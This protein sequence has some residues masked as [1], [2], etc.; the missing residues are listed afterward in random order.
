VQRIEHRHHTVLERLSDATIQPL[1][2]LPIALTVILVTFA[3]IRLI[4]EGLITLLLDPLFEVYRHAVMKLSGALGPGFL[5]EILIGKLID[6]KIDFVQSMGLLTTGLYVPF[7]MVLPYIFAFYLILSLLED[8]GYLPRLSVLLD[9]VFHKIGLHG[10]GIVTV[11]LGLGCNVPGALS[12]RILETRKQRFISA[13]LLC[14]S[15]PCMAQSAMIFGIL[16]RH[17]LGY[18]LIVFAT[19]VCVYLTAGLLLNRFLPGESPE[20]FLEI[21]PYRRPGIRPLLK[22][23]LMRV[24]SFLLEAVPFVFL[25]VLLINVLYATGIIELLGTAFAPVVSSLWGLPKEATASLL[26]GFL[27]KDVAVGMLLPLGLEASQLVVAATVLTVYFPCVATF[28]VL[29]RELGIKDMAK[30]TA[31]MVL[32][33][34]LVG[35]LLRVILPG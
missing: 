4:G 29:L 27:R 33:A 16:G 21:P 32:T 5:H 20:L 10:H 14:I 17:G 15:V 30:A 26:I 3:I 11:F 7:V 13:C 31:M 22:K 6:G 19:L 18:I 12:T 28:M 2:G 9:N 8:V 24:R 25:G 34:V 35:T 1:T 23:S